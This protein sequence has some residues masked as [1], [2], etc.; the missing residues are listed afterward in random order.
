MM[1]KI[2]FVS[3]VISVILAI[4]LVSG[5]LANNSEANKRIKAG[6]VFYN[7]MDYEKA[8]LAYTSNESKA[9]PKEV[10]K[11][12]AKEEPKEDIEYSIANKNLEN[13]IGKTAYKLDDFQL[14]IEKLEKNSED[15]LE[16]GNAYYK[17]A[18]NQEDPNVKQEN[19]EMAKDSYL[20]GIRENT[21]DV[22]L[23]YNYEFVK[24]SLDEIKEAQDKEKEE[25]EKKDQEKKDQEEP[26]ENQGEEN[27]DEESQQGDQ[28]QGEQGDESES[29]T[30]ENSDE[31]SDEEQ[32]QSGDKSDEAS[33]DEDG[34]SISNEDEKSNSEEAQSL[35]KINQILQ[36]LQSQ[37]EESLK[38]N[39]GIK[40][41]GKGEKND[42]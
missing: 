33:S 4:L 34:E 8:L 12:I 11:E 38:N 27:K 1:K 20:E 36:I 14:S 32:S 21:S 42:W 31:D 2:A 23:K 25:Q 40:T 28:Q 15:Y 19:L 3:G 35:E 5:M 41:D 6:N 17:Y 30:G 9:E 39:Q 29:Q 16:L 22:E 7:Q 37:E 26:G 24:N 10:P 18:L 13:N